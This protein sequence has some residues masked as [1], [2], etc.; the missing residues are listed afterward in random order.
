[1]LEY[2]RIDLSKGTDV[3]K[4]NSSKECGICYYRY[5]LDKGFKYEPYLCNDCHDLMQKAINVNDF[6]IV[7]VKGNDY[8]VHSWYMDKD[9]TI[10]MMKNSDLSEESVLL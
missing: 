10:N 1:M 8:R 3:N 7:S 6:A 4:T 2:N 5:F 9:D